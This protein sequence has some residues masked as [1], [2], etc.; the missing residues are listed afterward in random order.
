MG[1]RYGVRDEQIKKL[2]D[3]V[4]KLEEALNPFAEFGEKAVWKG[5]VWEEEPKTAVLVIED[6]AG[7]LQSLYMEQFLR[8]KKVLM[9]IT[10]YKGI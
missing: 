6:E 7:E 5:T 9:D 4:E 2:E 10:G 1:I 8:A 3:R